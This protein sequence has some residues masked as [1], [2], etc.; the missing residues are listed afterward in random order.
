MN[1]L[2]L[3]DGMSCGQIALDKLGINVDNYFASEIDKYAISVTQKNYPSTIQLGDINN[4]E[5]WV[6]PKIDLLIGG[7]PCQDLSRIKSK[8]GEGLLG[9][10]SKLFFKFVDCIEKFKPTY[11]LLENVLMNK[12]SEDVITELLG[13]VPIEINS[14]DFSAQDRKRLYWTNL[15]FS[16]DWIRSEVVLGD[17]L[18]K[19]YDIPNKYYYDENLEVVN[20]VSKRVYGTMAK[21]FVGNGKRRMTDTTS[22]VYN[23]LFK[24]A[25]LTAVSGG[26]QEKKVFVGD[27][28][29]KLTPLEYERL[30][31]VPENYT[32]SASDSQRYKMLGNGWTVDVI[33]HIFRP[34][35]EATE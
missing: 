10:K 7:S 19:E 34:L 26:H 20:G 17:I 5:D 6:L 18:Q 27:K 13:V 35:V 32:A 2:S 25:T 9:E 1:V 31:T 14:G 24:C 16:H 33:A 28:I 3:F 23:P 8:D 11:F 29:R 12:E 15:P 21:F 30:Q 4:L 22:R